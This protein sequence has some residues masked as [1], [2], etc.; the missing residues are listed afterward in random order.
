MASPSKMSGYVEEEVARVEVEEGS[1]SEAP[2][3]TSGSESEEGESDKA[4]I[5]SQDVQEPI[6]D[7]QRSP[8]D[9]SDGAS[10][11]VEAPS[12][13][14]DVPTYKIED[15][16]GFMAQFHAGIDDKAKMKAFLEKATMETK[17]KEERKLQK[18]KE[19]KEKADRERESKRET[20]EAMVTL[21]IQCGDGSGTVPIAISGNAT[22]KDL[23]EAIQ[24]ACFKGM[25]KKTAKTMQIYVVGELNNLCL[26]PRKTVNGLGLRDGCDGTVLSAKFG[27]T[28]GGFANVRK[29]INKADAIKN[30]KDKAVSYAT[31]DDESYNIDDFDEDFQKFLKEQVSK[32]NSVK[33]LVSQGIDVVGVSLSTTSDANLTFI[34][35]LLEK[36]FKGKA[37]TSEARVAVVVEKLFPTLSLLRS[38]SKALS[39]LHGEMM[40]YIMGLYA[41]KF[42][43][44]KD[45]DIMYNH[46]SFLGLIEKEMMKR[47]IVS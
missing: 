21:N 35:E 15:D 23:R 28:G 18:E 30:L 42:Y 20:R 33:M 11:T 6:N 44:F 38:A 47:D 3:S 39:S 19:K 25:S 46:S 17:E 31:K 4:S 22:V 29:S 2:S 41:E 36:K 14:T 9:P 27:L 45:D 13:S 5:Q 34:K 32:L 7:S 24:N 12:G 8:R 40:G 10:G 43:K 37:D 1:E 16:I 26:A